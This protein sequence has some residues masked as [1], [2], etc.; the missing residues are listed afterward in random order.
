MT[1]HQTDL[2]MIIRENIIPKIWLDPVILKQ[3]T[4]V[5]K[6]NQNEDKG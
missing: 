5:L 4:N 6:V 2:E 3:W 1:L